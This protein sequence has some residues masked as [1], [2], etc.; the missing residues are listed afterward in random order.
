MD[1]EE[2]FQDEV[3]ILNLIAMLMIGILLFSG[4][5]ET[6]GNWIMDRHDSQRSG[7]SPSEGP[8]TAYFLWKSKVADISVAI[9]PAATTTR[10]TDGIVCLDENGERVWKLEERG[11]SA[12]IINES[13][14]VGSESELYCLRLVDGSIVWK[15][16]TTVASG[17]P[18]LTEDSVCFAP[19]ASDVIVIDPI[20]IGI[21]GRLYELLFGCEKCQI[22]CHDIHT[23]EKSWTYHEDDDIESIAYDQGHFIVLLRNGKVYCLDKN[24][25]KKLWQFRSGEK[26]SGYPALHTYQVFFSGE[27]H[28][29]CLD[30]DTGHV[31]WKVPIPEGSSPALAYDRVYVSSSEGYLYCVDAY[32]G[33]LVWKASIWEDSPQ[34]FWKTFPVSP[35]VADDKV[36]VGS[37]DRNIYAFNAQDGALLWKYTLG[38]AI[39][40][41]PAIVDGKILVPCTDGFLYA[42]GID[43]ETYV[44]KAQK[45]LEKRDYEKAQEYF[46]KAREWYTQKGDYG[47][48][49]ACDESIEAVNGEIKDYSLISDSVKSAEEY[50]N[51]GNEALLR[52]KYDNALEL[53]TLSKDSYERIDD[54]SRMEKCCQRIEY[55][56]GRIQEKDS[57]MI[58]VYSIIVILVCII[59][60]LLKMRYKSK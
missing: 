16:E 50:F 45:Y 51:Q 12:I 35:I 28:V 3:A 8:D 58:I 39:V 53:F 22:T 41:S 54:T 20:W 55:I 15:T 38:G 4:F 10:I 37:P 42:F 23:G 49:A 27:F 56:K 59:V 48:V 36:F 60:L 5:E 46:H 17:S 40:A 33:E 13:V 32:T 31:F 19:I 2:L 30:G 11:A 43:P 9:T 24:T 21:L 57:Q 47:K 7:F 1:H 34:E 26:A 52:R 29:Y 6:N 14:V 25:E 18:V 44:Q